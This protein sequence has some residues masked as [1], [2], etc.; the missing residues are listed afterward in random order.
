MKGNKPDLTLN[1]DAKIYLAVAKQH[2]DKLAFVYTLACHKSRG[3][4]YSLQPTREIHTFKD[5][6]TADLYYETINQIV[7]LNIDRDELKNIFE[8]NNDLI[9]KFNERIK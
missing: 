2:T 7:E 5:K 6:E 1:M 4:M 3:N 9:V 8:F